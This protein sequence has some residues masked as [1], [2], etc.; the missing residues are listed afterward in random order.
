MVIFIRDIVNSCDTNDQGAVVSNAVLPSLKHGNPVTLDF[1]GVFN[2]TTSFVNTAFVDLL[3]QITF[4]SIKTH[5]II[6]NANRQVGALI[7]D[8]MRLKAESLHI[9][10]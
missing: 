1:S 7:K 9:A 8:R 2:A 4:D 6:Q 5:L 3:D 10:A